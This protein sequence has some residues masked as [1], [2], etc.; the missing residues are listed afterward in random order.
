MMTLLRYCNTLPDVLLGWPPLILG[1]RR[2]PDAG[3][4]SCGDCGRRAACRRFGGIRVRPGGGGAE[5][6]QG[7]RAAVDL[8]DA[9]VRGE[10]AR[11]EPAQRAERAQDAGH[12]PGARV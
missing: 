4:E 7:P 1:E 3:M 5:L 9:V 10:A 2:G 6:R 11:G 8:H 12:R